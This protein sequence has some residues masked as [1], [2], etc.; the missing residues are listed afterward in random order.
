MIGVLITSKKDWKILLDLYNITDLYLEKY[1]Y[2]EFYKTKFQNKDVTFFRIGVRKTNS[3]AAT[4][5]IIDKFEIEKFLLIGTCSLVTD[6]L[7]YLDI[8]IP[9]QSIDYDLICDNDITEGMFINYEEP[10]IK[11]KYYETIIASSDKKTMDM[12]DIKSLASQG[13]DVHD[14][15]TYSVSKVCQMNN[16]KIMVIKGISDKPI[17]N[18]KNYYEQIDV[19][20]E[21]MP[22][23]IKNILENYM[24]EVIK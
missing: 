16:K 5:Y 12:D 19:Y 10:N 23:I 9:T 6:E 22:I 15:E 18:D 4:Q 7:N 24:T 20:N 2:G 13:I 8:V 14:V 21:N 3:S 17:K 1:P 11:C